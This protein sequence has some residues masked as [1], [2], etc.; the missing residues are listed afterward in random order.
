M[1]HLFIR[2]LLKQHQWVHVPYI[3]MMKDDDYFERDAYFLLSEFYSIFDLF[4]KFTGLRTTGK[5]CLLSSV[6]VL[7]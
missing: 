7:N 1:V 6:T 3:I 4:H 5:T 2:V